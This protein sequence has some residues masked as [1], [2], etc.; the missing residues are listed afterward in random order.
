[1]SMPKKN[2][3]QNLR[4]KSFA[5]VFRG[6]SSCRIIQPGPLASSVREKK[7]FCTSELAMMTLFSILALF[8]SMIQSLRVMEYVIVLVHDFP[9]LRR[10]KR[11][12]ASSPREREDWGCGLSLLDPGVL[13]NPDRSPSLLPPHRS[14]RSRHRALQLFSS[15]W[16]NQVLEDRR[17]F[18]VPGSC[19]YLRIWRAAVSCLL[20][21]MESHWPSSGHWH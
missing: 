8:L 17:C 6:S 1:M 7:N 11:K 12:R 21:C 4:S 16:I 2:D 3:R 9:K 20:Y 18:S 14:N 10:K 5:V 13:S 15:K 19:R